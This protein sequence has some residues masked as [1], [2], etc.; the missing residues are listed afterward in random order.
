MFSAIQSGDV[1]RGVVP[2]ENSTNGP[3]YQTLDLFVDP[4]GEHVDVRVCGDVFVPVHHCLLGYRRQPSGEQAD[5]KSSASSVPD[6]SY[7]KT[8]YTHPQAW[9]QCTPFLTTHLPHAEHHDSSSTSAAA[10][11][12]AADRSGASASISSALAASTHSLDVLASNIETRADNTTRFLIL[13]RVPDCGLADLLQSP[14]VFWTASEPPG[15]LASP[16][17]PWRTLLSFSVPHADPGA[18]ARALAVFG[19]HG[20]NLA[21]LAARPSGE[22]PWHYV[23]FVELWGVWFPDREFAA[24]GEIAAALRE[25]AGVVQSWTWLGC[26][27]TSE[28]AVRIESAKGKAR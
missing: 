15:P 26:W 22:R 12:A 21:S 13:R 6:L 19:A 2:F 24:H 3:V 25:L 14:A 1:E 11:L 9:T 28:E 23:F 20:V 7:I 18:L 5:N 4:S 16:G 10:A 8:L 27:E 17:P